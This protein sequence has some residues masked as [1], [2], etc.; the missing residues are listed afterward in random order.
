[1][2]P[3]P[4]TTEA[5]EGD[6]PPVSIVICTYTDRRWS[7]LR[8]AIK[9]ALGQC[10]PEDEVVVVVD[11]NPEL[12]ARLVA[13][14]PREG[15]AM[16]RVIDNADVKGLSGARNTGVRAA[17]N[18]V[19][20]FLDDDAVPAPGWLEHLVERVGEPGVVGAGGWVRP[21]WEGGEPRW[22]P[23]T[24]NW[25]VGCSYHGLPGE[26]HRLRNPIGASMALRRTDIVAAG[27]F[28]SGV[29]RVDDKPHG[30]EETEICIK[31]SERNPGAEIVHATRSV[32]EH[33]VPAGRR[34]VRYFA[35][36]CLAEGRSKAIVAEAVGTTSALASEK[37]H[38]LTTIP[39]DAARDIVA[40]P[41]GPARAA[42]ASMGLL[43]TTLGY[44][45]GRRDARRLPT[46]PVPAIQYGEAA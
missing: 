15:T 33:H 46:A 31:I 26:G 38:A 19:T 36:R 7:L 12:H 4:P 16:V 8:A 25:V 3:P 9:T 24:F 5:R 22:W 10:R 42:A 39:V 29:G 43:L 18:E 6:R 1:M 27:M 34:S 32:V 2:I 30:C 14:M 41:T 37:V 23:R 11:H 45:R 40:S 28:R 13:E 20:V 44:V 17:G 35:R 21:A